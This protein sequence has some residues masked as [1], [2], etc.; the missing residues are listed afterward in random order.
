MKAKKRKKIFIGVAWPYVN[1][2]LHIGHLAGYLLPADIFAR[3]QRLKGNNVL[4]V[5]G[6]DCHG[7]PIT[8][9][10]EKIGKRPAEIVRKYHKKHRELFKLYEISFDIYTKTTTRNH[11]ETVQKIF[12]NLLKR[13]FIFK[14]KSLQYFSEKENRFLPDRYVEGKCP[15]CG[16]P[17]ARGDQCDRCGAIIGEG[18]LINPKSKISKTKVIL[19]ETEHYYID[20]P[21]FKKFLKRYLKNKRKLWRKWILK[22]SLGWLKKGLKSRSITRDINWGIKI[23]TKKIPKHL[24][25][26]NA[27]Q[28]R[29][30]VWFEAVIGYLS[31]SIEWSKKR[32]KNWKEFWFS[33]NNI[34]HYYFMGKDNLFFHSILFPSQLYGAFKKIHL[35]DYLIVNQFLTFE[36]K[37]FSKSRNVIIESSYI[38]KKYGVDPVRFYLT[39]ISPET[40]DS[41]FTWEDFVNVN[42]NVLIGNI[43]NFIH[44]TLKLSKKTKGINKKYIEKNVE[45]NI[46]KYLNNIQKNLERCNFKNYVREVINLSS[47]GNKYL[48]EKSPWTLQKESEDFKKTVSNALF[49]IL[50]LYL[51]LIPLIPNSTQKLSQFLN[52]K[53]EK[54]PEKNT[55][56]FLK[57]YLRKIK[58]K[59]EKVLFQKIDLSVIEKEKKKISLK[60]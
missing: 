21:K 11:K 6:S 33:K 48:E 22:E 55:I 45:K 52:V 17:Y 19:K 12:L 5:S 1:G 42:N 43:G 40:T 29:I 35:P 47:F 41:S 18:E 60:R 36:E 30:Y 58:I 37:P 24:R 9:E 20:L 2:T 16:Y 26:K 15:Y 8:L 53:I 7:T 34:S 51:S 38:G 28:K 39:L 46:K 23:P 14:K 27:S 13:G 59:R 25:I 56:S 49:I 44:R 4:M 54:W 10:A 3:F 31:A 50:A 32:K 57:K